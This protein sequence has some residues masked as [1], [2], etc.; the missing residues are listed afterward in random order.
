MGILAG[1][2]GSGR[3]EIIEKPK[4]EEEPKFFT[5]AFLNLGE[6]A[7]KQQQ[8]ETQK[9]EAAKAAAAA[10][11]SKK[12]LSDGGLDTGIMKAA[13]KDK[14]RPISSTPVPGTPWCVVWTGDLRS[15]FYN[16]TN[17]QSVWE[18][19]AEMVGRSDVAKMLESP[20]AAEEFKKRQQQKALPVF[21]EPVAKKARVVSEQT[22]VVMTIGNEEVMIIKDDTSKK[23]PQGKEAAI[24]AEVR[25]ARERAMVPLETRMLQFRGLLEE[26]QVSAFSSWEKEL[27][28][29][30]FDPRYLL[31]TSKERKTVF[32]KYVRER[33]DEERK[34][35]KAKA[36]ERKENFIELCKEVGVTPK[37]S[38]SEFSREQAKDERF[39]AIEKSRDRET[40]FNDYVSELKKEEKDEKRKAAKKGFKELLKETEGIDHHSHWSD[41][42]K[43]IS[44]DPRY[45]AVDKSNDREDWFLD[46]VQELKDEHRKEKDKKRAE[47]SRSRSSSRGKKKKRSGSRS[48]S[49]DKKKKKDKD[50]S[51]SR[52]RS[53]EK[54]KK[55]EKD[56]KKEK[57]KK[58]DKEE[59]EMSDEDGDK[60]SESGEKEG[61]EEEEGKQNGSSGV[62]GNTADQ[63][64]DSGEKPTEAEAEK[65]ERVAAA[66]AARQEAV[67]ADMAGH[68]RDRDKER[69]SH[70]HTEAVNAFSALL[71][72]LIR[73]PDF[74]WT[75][76]KKILKKDSRYEALTGGEAALDKS[77][78]ERLFDTHID[79]LI[80][81]KKTAFRSLLEEQKEVALDAAFKDIKKLIKEDPRYT[82]FSTSDKKCEKEF[83]AWLRDRVSKARGDYRQLLQET[84]LITHK[85]LQ[86]IK[87]KEGNHMEDIEEVLCKDSR[88]HIMEPLND[89]RA[90][91]LM[92][93]LEE[94]RG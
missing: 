1:L 9:A 66:L 22:P 73:A 40:H 36:K 14:S 16:P 46:Y 64:S 59:G 37:S 25:A 32:D 51:R 35:K 39:K 56:V 33:A 78:R 94:E 34:E 80:A 8:Q 81:K 72:D 57:K 92:S 47:R 77:E 45:A 58:K 21:E 89:D 18:K 65:A 61:E 17:K 74:S 49:R 75:E 50:R 41:F 42:K 12:N 6:N 20:Q 28:K 15:F 82:K 93:Y 38:W 4:A 70:L 54:S 31:L 19:P 91:I 87:D 62:N 2:Q 83:V 24:E 85:S 43:M 67:K 11:L 29:I 84:K 68:L 60:R 5:P 88:Y 52:S 7:T 23:L 55:K 3:V 63:D 71:A 44:E 79:E 69:E 30:V 76:A 48:R 90:D 27:S 86:M 53:H 10:V 26:K 13:P